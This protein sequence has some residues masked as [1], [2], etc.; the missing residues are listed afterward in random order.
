MISMSYKVST[1]TD[2]HLKGPFH[3]RQDTWNCEDVAI[4]YSGE[5]SPE[6]QGGPFRSENEIKI[7]KSLTISF[8]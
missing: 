3:L 5:V 7:D 4:F 8:M 6:D 2:I 1:L